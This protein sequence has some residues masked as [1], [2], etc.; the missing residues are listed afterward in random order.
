MVVAYRYFEWHRSID[1][2]EFCPY[3]KINWWI[4]FKFIELRI[5][6]GWIMIGILIKEMYDKLR[7]KKHE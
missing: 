7:G 2:W 3:F 6:I 4:A 5:I 1:Y